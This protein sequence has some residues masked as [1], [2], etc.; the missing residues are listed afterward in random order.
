MPRINRHFLWSALLILALAINLLN[1]N[2]VRADGETPPPPEATEEPTEPPTEPTA[3]PIVIE[4]TPTPLPEAMPEGLE[5]TEIQSEN[6]EA[7]TFEILAD[8]PA[9]TTVVALD[10]N[11]EP[12][13]LSTQEAASILIEADPI[14]CP[15][16]QA[17]PTPGANGCTTSQTITSLLTLMRTNAG[18]T[19]SQAGVIYLEKPGGAGFTTPLI[20]DDSASSLNTSFALVAGT[21]VIRVHYLVIQ[22][23]AP[24]ES[25]RDSYRLVQPQIHG[26]EVSHFKMLQ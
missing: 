26:R 9:E 11:G 1:V 3:E 25:T 7:A 18:G 24:V 14:W 16:A 13:S 21:G 12:V 5:S 15:A 2:V 10:E 22:T 23:S 19:F 6:S 8:L 17:I 4:A 20:L